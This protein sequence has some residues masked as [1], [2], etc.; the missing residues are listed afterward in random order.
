MSLF[1]TQR[2]IFTIL[3]PPGPKVGEV[4]F[5]NTEKQYQKR[6]G[7]K[8]VNRRKKSERIGGGNAIT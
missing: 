4:I 7:K 2:Y 6:K 1:Y 5:N 8:E 3:P